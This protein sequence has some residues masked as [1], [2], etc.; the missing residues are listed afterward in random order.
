[1]KKTIIIM[2]M[3]SSLGNFYFIQAYLSL[4][5]NMMSLTQL[6]EMYQKLLTKINIK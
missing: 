6:F 2:I 1:M 5:S 3:I 4:M